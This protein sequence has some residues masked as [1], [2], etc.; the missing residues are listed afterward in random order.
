VVQLATP[1]ELASYLQ[2]DLDTSTA[3]LVLDVASG[4][5]EDA[6]DTKFAAS[7]ATT[8]FEGRGQTVLALPKHP[9]IAVSQVRV[10]SVIVAS[11]AYF[12]VGQNL[13]RVSG[14]GGRTWHPQKV[15]VD[16]TYGFTSVPDDV[17]GAVLE[18]AGAGYGNPA[19]ATREQIDDYAIQ[20]AA[21]SGGVGLTPNAE[22]VA[23]RYR[24]AGFA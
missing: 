18:M 14:W 23:N 6:A 4:E 1:A 11:T 16:Y 22:K 9:V 5:F 20:Y 19:A 12:L 2:Q 8:T 7:S 10:D 17:K 24:F 15:E 3:N 13:Y 21:G